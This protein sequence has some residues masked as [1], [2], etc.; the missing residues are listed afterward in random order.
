MFKGADICSDSKEYFEKDG[1]IVRYYDTRKNSVHYITYRRCRGK[2][3]GRR[4]RY[5][6]Y[7]ERNI[8]IVV[9]ILLFRK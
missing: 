7:R 5:G 3:R 2:I 4:M 8:D 6:R 1:N 9:G